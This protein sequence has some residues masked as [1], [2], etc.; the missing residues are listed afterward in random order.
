M[1]MVYKAVFRAVE[2]NPIDLMNKEGVNDWD[3]FYIV[4]I[5]RVGSQPPPPSDR[6]YTQLLYFKKNQ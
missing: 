5:N 4:D 6:Q 1:P 2:E 3:C